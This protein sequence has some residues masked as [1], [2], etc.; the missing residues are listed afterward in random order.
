[1]ISALTRLRL[2]F[3]LK[4]SEACAQM[5]NAQTPSRQRM[6]NNQQK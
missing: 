2:V 6:P 5:G 1:L 4:V 3:Q